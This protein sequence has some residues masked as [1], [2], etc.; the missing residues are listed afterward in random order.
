MSEA[1]LIGNHQIM[2]IEGQRGET[3]ACPEA[4]FAR[5]DVVKISRRKA[6]EHLPAELIVAVA[7]PPN[8]S[9]DWA[10]ADLVGEPRPLIHQV[11]SRSITYILVRENDPK[12][13]LLKE[14]DMRPSGKEPV[15]FGQARRETD[16][17]AAARE[18][19]ATQT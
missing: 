8:F 11:G 17:D 3:P 1:L 12:P 10:L 6:C 15:A 7:I 2:R 4:K 13:Y 5:G 16:E 9:P 19:A 18:A 14:R